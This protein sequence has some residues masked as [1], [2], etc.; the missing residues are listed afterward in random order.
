MTALA[1]LP[2]KRQWQSINKLRW[3]PMAART[4]ATRA[5]PA[6]RARVN[7]GVPRT[8]EVTSS[9]GAILTASKPAATACSEL[10]ATAPGDLMWVRLLMLAY[11]G[12]ELLTSPTLDSRQATGCAD[13]C[14]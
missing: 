4:A 13:R 5:N 1:V 11:K 10:A 8:E 2:S 6:S 14:P 3:A 12:M 9:K 7:C